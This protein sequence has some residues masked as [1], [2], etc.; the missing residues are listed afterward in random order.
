[1]TE[2]FNYIITTICNHAML[3]V[4]C[5]SD[6]L[7]VFV[8]ASTT[9]VGGVLCVSRDDTWMPT[10]FYS[11]QLQSREIKDLATELEALALL[12]TIEYFSYYLSGRDFVAYT[13]TI[14]LSPTYWTRHR[15][16]TNCTDGRRDCLYLMSQS[17]ISLESGICWRMHQARMA[18]TAAATSAAALNSTKPPS[19]RGG[20]CG[21]PAH[22][23][24][25][26]HHTMQEED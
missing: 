3:I 19:Q 15:I 16:Q 17:F 26:A 1:M 22:Y 10:A 24:G 5:S 18:A 7:C 2:S 23:Y 13:A 25:L 14:L 21:D 4:P 11:R 8:D 6:A 20:R 12:T 9:G